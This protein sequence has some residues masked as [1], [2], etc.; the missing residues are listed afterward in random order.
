MVGIGAMLIEKRSGARWDLEVCAKGIG[1]GNPSL[2]HL[3]R[4]QKLWIICRH[5]INQ[6]PTFLFGASVFIFACNG[7]LFNA[8]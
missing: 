8:K 6:V 4:L 3:Q 1:I 5:L 2:E 7:L